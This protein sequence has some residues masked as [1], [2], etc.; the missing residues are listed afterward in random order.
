MN[1]SIFSI[2]N[3]AGRIA[4]DYFRRPSAFV[5]PRL[6]S[7]NLSAMCKVYRTM[8]RER[9]KAETEKRACQLTT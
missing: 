1:T 2:D 5:L 3:E 6:D 9:L 7:P 8:N 4:S